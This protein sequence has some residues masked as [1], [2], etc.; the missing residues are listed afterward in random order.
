MLC[1]RER[2][3]HGILGGEDGQE[4][5]SPGDHQATLVVTVEVAREKPG[6][7]AL[8]AEGAACAK[9]WRDMRVSHVVGMQETQD[10]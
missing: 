7:R 8:Q 3:W 5:P 1:A 6:R 9:V 10:G 4:R 2:A